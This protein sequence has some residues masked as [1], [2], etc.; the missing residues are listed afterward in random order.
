MMRRTELEQ[1]RDALEDAENA[2]EEIR[3]QRPQVEDEAKRL[4]MLLQ[5]N[6][7]AA[8][9]RRAFAGKRYQ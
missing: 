8:R 4:S 9:M 7:L 1:A 5:E 6:N 3:Q 2:R